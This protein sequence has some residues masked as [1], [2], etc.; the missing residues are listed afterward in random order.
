M[1]L[2]SFNKDGE[3]RIGILDRGTHE[4]VD[5]RAVAPTFTNNM[6]VLI[7]QGV[8][9]IVQLREI[10]IS[11][12]GCLPLS[13]VQLR[14]PIPVLK[15]NIFCVGKNYAE[16]VGEVN[17]AMQTDRNDIPSSPIFFSKATTSL[18]AT[19][20]PIL[21]SLDHTHSVDYEGELAVV[22]AKR[23]RGISTTDAMSY[24]FGYTILNDVTSRRLQKKHQQWFLGKSLDSFCPLGPSIVTRDDVSDVGQF[25]IE[26]HVNH[27]LRQ[28]G[29]VKQMIFSIP[30]LISTLSQSMTLL[31]GDIIATGTPSGVGMGFSP[32]RFLKPGDHVSVSIEPIGTLINTV[33]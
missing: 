21:A 18:I 17:A 20:E 15:R 6:L 19:G 8:D 12:D 24:V 4:V 22:I 16:H 7:E 28:W 13:G 2:V 26:T 9:A 32:P 1:H 30:E 3:L 25:V 27:E 10:F 11:G 29:Q 33:E 31:P 14:A 23:G 5:V